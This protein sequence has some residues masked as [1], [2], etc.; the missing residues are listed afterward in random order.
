[1]TALRQQAFEMLENFPAD[2][3][4]ALISFMQG[5]MLK[6]QETREARLERKRLA[7]EKFKSLCK[8][9]PNLDEKAELA[10]YREERFGAGID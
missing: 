5:E 4:F 3:L 1:M 8:P 10:K 2:K 9:I 6:S 7:H